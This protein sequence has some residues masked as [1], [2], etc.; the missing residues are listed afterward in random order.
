MVL[1]IIAIGELNSWAKLAYDDYAKRLNGPFA[2]QSVQ[3]PTPKRSKNLT[4]SSAMKSEASKINKHLDADDFIITL[5][6][7][8]KS[9]TT[10]QFTQ[11]LQSWMSHK[12]ACFILGGPD[13]LS[14]EIQKSAQ[15]RLSLSSMVLPHAL[16]RVMLIEQLY[17]AY[18]LTTNH[19]YHRA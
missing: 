9:F 8:G 4:T 2:I 16:A 14:G 11:A 17:R 1:K 18:T 6:Q 12:R 13:G 15:A 19:P 5:D 10:E 7:R 3:I